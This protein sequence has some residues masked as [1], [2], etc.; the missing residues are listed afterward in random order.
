MLTGIPQPSRDAY[1]KLKND[2]DFKRFL[3]ALN[4]IGEEASDS[5]E[6]EKAIGR[7]QM[8]YTSAED[9]LYAKGYTDDEIEGALA[10]HDILLESI[11]GT[12]TRT[13]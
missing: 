2:S 8:R 6:L 4:F 12:G 1:E 3:A 5:I 9:Q 10:Y 7:C 13:D 11:Y